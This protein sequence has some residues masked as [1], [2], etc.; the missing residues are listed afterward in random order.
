MPDDRDQLP[1]DSPAPDPTDEA[2]EE[3]NTDDEANVATASQTP[4]EDAPAE[5]VAARIEEIP[6]DEGAG[7]LEG[8]DT[9]HAADVV[10]T[11][12]P[13]TAAE[14]V[15]EMDP[16]LAATVIA[17]M[18]P[19]EASM[20]LAEM[21]PDDR[22]D[23]LGLLP[24]E[25]HD[26]VVRELDPDVAA[27]V[28]AL[29]QY[30]P[31][32]A[33]GIMTTEVTAL[34]E[35]LTVEEA[36]AELRRMSEKLEQMYYVY[37]IDKRRHLVGVLSMRDLIMARPGTTLAR[38]MN[39]DVE[40][41]QALEDQEKVAAQMRRS[42]YLAMPVVDPRGHL[43]G[44]ITVD[45]IVEVLEEETTEDVQKLFGAGGEERLT[46][47]W[48]FSF[49]KRVV[50]LFV[51]L[52]TAFLAAS[53]VGAFEGTIEKLAILAAYMPIVAGMGGNASA[54]AMAVT[55]RGIAVGRVDR[56][57]LRHVITR[58]TIVG[59]AN[60]TLLGIAT[61]LIATVAH[62]G[63][64]STGEHLAFGLVVGIALAANMTLAC[65]A[66][67]GL[68][69]ILRRLGFDPAQSASIFATSITDIAGFFTLLGLANVFLM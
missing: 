17:D 25:M 33:G 54:Q 10:E 30:P 63:E 53:V 38:V 27:E 13:V 48:H 37:V 57:L 12:D 39:T 41:V 58:E 2:L 51:N 32:S 18:E 31:D 52:A 50:W 16:V 45:D 14:I 29:E 35:H 1:P 24:P 8:L 4:H 40:S 21:D 61:G 66:G 46:S 28:R 65:I 47:A 56:K 62:I 60:G 64:K 42:G 11:L 69:F 3:S 59:L 7:V 22:V 6:A 15:T 44:I 49:R 23:I 34:H 9:Q 36:I 5:E 68:P 26:A 55:I 67:S 19:A 43:V 20:V